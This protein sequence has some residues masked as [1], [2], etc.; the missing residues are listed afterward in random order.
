M[1]AH[2]GSRFF[3]LL[4][5]IWGSNYSVRNS[6]GAMLYIL[7]DSAV[8][9]LSTDT[10]LARPLSTSG[11]LICCRGQFF[12]QRQ[13]LAILVGRAKPSIETPS[14]P[15]SFLTSPLADLPRLANQLPSI[16][17]SV[18]WPDAVKSGR[19][20]FPIT[21]RV[22]LGDLQPGLC[23]PYAFIRFGSFLLD[24]S[25]HKGGNDSRQIGQTSLCL[26]HPSRHSLWKM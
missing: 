16:A 12:H 24:S 14:A 21:S 5:R 1:P 4:S 19:S 11:K 18:S 6:A 7:I 26:I 3:S 25:L 23:I 9:A 15:P 20:E 22:D 2:L 8:P 17:C 13:F 10:T